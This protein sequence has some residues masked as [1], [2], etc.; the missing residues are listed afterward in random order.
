MGK[1]DQ[2]QAQPGPVCSRE[3]LD[4]V[5]AVFHKLNPGSPFDF[6]FADDQ[7]AKKF[8]NEERIAKASLC[9]CQFSGD[10]QL[11]WI[12]WAGLLYGRAAYEGNRRTESSWR[13]ASQSAGTFVQRFYAAGDYLLP[14]F[15][16]IGLVPT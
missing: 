15:R 11:S 5:E 2:Y 3:S 12:I 13:I 4:K 16:S 10:D 1:C 9:V 14:Y 6:R 8:S 7:F